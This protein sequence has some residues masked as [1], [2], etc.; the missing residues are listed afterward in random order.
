MREIG[1]LPDDGEARRFGDYLLTR[2]IK[3]R[4]DEEAEG[5]SIWVFDEDR[6]DDAKQEFNEFREHSDAALYSEAADAASGLRRE[7]ARQQR[8]IKKNFV[9]VKD[10]WNR[11]LTSRCPVTVIVLVVTVLTA[12]ATQLGHGNETLI[13]DLSISS[14]IPTAVTSSGGLLPEVRSGQIWRLVT[15]IF[16][17]FG[18]LHIAFNCYMFFQFGMVTESLRGSLRFVLM[19]LLIA[20]TSNLAQYL[21]AGPGFGGLSGVVYGLFG[22]IWMK[23]K[24]DPGSGFFMHPTTVFWLMG[25]FLLCMTGRVGRIANTAHTVGLAVG[26]ILGIAPIFWRDLLRNR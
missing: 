6:V 11:P 10:R 15:P 3:S 9:E 22:Y 26:M 1:R 14:V 7:E 25:W 8:Q 5:F 17:H 13:D 4:I 2:G 21:R 16:L 20:V 23:S 19:V 18:L 24:F 12:F